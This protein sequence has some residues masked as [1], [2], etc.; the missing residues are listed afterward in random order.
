MNVSQVAETDSLASP[1]VTA[2]EPPPK[3]ADLHRDPDLHTPPHSQSQPY[4]QSQPHTQPH[5]QTQQPKEPQ[6]DRERRFECP[7]C[8]KRFL[9]RQDLSRHSATHLNGFKPFHCDHCGTGFT[10]QDAL[11]RHGKAKKCAEKRSLS[12]DS[13]MD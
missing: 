4:A 8:A 9:R 10:R 5:P 11:H 6:P 2:Y 3:I 12:N 7:E 13:Q 1:A